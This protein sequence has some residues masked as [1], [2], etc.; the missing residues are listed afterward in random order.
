MVTLGETQGTWT[1]V[2][3][4]ITAGER[5]VASLTPAVADGVRFTEQP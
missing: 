3:S 1:E 2:L 5:V 4:G